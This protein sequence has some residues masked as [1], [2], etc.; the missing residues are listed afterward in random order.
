MDCGPLCL[1][2]IVGALGGFG[3]GLLINGGLVSP[4]RV[5]RA[6]KQP[7]LELG[8]ITSLLILSG[9]GA[10]WV[11]TLDPLGSRKDLGIVFITGLG[12]D[13]FLSNL[14]QKREAN[15][16]AEIANQFEAVVKKELSQDNEK[17]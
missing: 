2:A 17:S 10:Y 5:P 12:G 1:C 16:Q 15:T 4:R 3:N 6:Q 7:V 11:L 9:V 14:M 13:S 8:T